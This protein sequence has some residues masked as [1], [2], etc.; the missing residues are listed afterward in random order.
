MLQQIGPQIWVADGPQIVAAAGF[1]Y[2]TRM[3]IIRLANGDLIVIS[4]VAISAELQAALAA[5]GPVAHLVAPNS[6]HHM[7]MGDWMAAYPDAKTYAAPRL[8]TKRKDLRFDKDLGDL[9][10]WSG[11]VDTLLMAP[12]LITDEVVFFHRASGT[13]VFT[14]LIQQ[15]PQGWFTGLRA[16]IAKLDLM[17][18]NPPTVPRKFRLGFRNRRALAAQVAVLNGWPVQRL[19][20]AHGPI[21]Q[22]GAAEVLRRAFDWVRP[23]G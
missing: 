12:H 19:V 18:S 1:H 13:A 14:D 6:L 2:P 21:V 16:L 3:T 7:A 4:P 8:P 23:L 20:M 15:L 22:D 5:L 11:E 10:P 17:Q 9:S